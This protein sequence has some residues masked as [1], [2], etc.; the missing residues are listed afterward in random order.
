V[1]PPECLHVVNRVVH[2]EPLPGQLMRSVS[3][4]KCGASR[5]EFTGEDWLTTASGWSKPHVEGRTHGTYEVVDGVP[6]VWIRLDG[7]DGPLVPSSRK[8][9]VPDGG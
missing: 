2:P 7:P 4:C 6:T 8:P 9:K 3:Y 1:I 5:V